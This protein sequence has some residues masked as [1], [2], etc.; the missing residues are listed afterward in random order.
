[1]THKSQESAL[2]T[3]TAKKNPQRYNAGNERDA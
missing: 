2:F 3:I 1:M